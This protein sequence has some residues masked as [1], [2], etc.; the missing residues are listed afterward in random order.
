MQ[1]AL[2]TSFHLHAEEGLEI[3]QEANT[4]TQH[5]FNYTQKECHLAP[6]HMGR[7]ITSHHPH[8]L[9]L[10]EGASTSP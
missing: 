7:A 1:D 10:H 4:V 2:P 5:P 6:S 3:L 9:P 8:K